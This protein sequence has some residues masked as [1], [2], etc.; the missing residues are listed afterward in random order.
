MEEELLFHIVGK[1]YSQLTRSSRK[2]ADYILANKAEAQFLSITALAEEC[3]VAEASVTRF[4]RSLGFSGYSE[5]KIA[6]AK[7]SVQAVNPV[8]A[9]QEQTTYQGDRFYDLCN[10]LFENNVNSIR[11]TQ[12]RL[13]EDDVRQTINYISQAKRV[14]CLGQGGSLILAMEAWGRFVTVAPNFV[15]I[16]DSHLQIMNIAVAEPGDVILFF[17]YSGSTRD[18]QELLQIAKKRGVKIILV[19]HYTKSPGATLADIV[20][21]CGSDESP[22]QGGSVAVKMANLYIIDVLFHEYCRLNPQTSNINNIATA[23]AVATKLL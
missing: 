15:F 12:N 23:E 6:L 14:Y 10:E 4:C 7:S 5:F 16:E 13:R 3:D 18:M 11:K 22:L 17:S 1:K 21:L 2:I 8:T 20:I 19:T 9:E